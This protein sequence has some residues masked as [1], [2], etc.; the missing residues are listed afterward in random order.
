MAT[1]L[2]SDQ[3]GSC[4]HLLRLCSP[5]LPVG[6]YSYSNGLEWAVEAGWVGDEEGA[7]QWIVGLLAGPW[8]Y[9]ETPL[10]FRL[11]RAWADDD[12]PRA[13]RWNDLL[14]ACREA[15]E[16]RAAETGMGQ[17][18][19]RLLTELGLDK[20]Q[21]WVAHPRA[22]FAAMFALA[23][24]RWGIEADQACAGY[25]WTLAENQAAAGVKLVP[26]GQTAGQRILSRALAAIPR[27][28]AQ[29]M[30]LAD[31]E[32]GYAAPGLALAS[33]RHETQ[34]TRLFRS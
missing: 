16:M 4:L 13:R 8:T 25:L 6:A 32:I 29:G 21:E 15:R 1:G 34:R 30:A 9:L 22:T 12:Q 19:A 23:T 28:V 5:A 27:A 3:I 26:L 31:D 2:F 17:A 7:A 20:A 10:M 14:L 11:H 33:A 18:L 24:A